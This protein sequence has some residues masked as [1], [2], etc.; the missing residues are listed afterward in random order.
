MVRMGRFRGLGLLVLL[1]SAGLAQGEWGEQ[2]LELEPGWNAVFLE[3]QPLEN[4]CAEVFAGLPVES[5]WYWNKRFEPVQFVEDPGNLNPRQPDWLAWFPP[6]HPNAFLTDLFAVMAGDCYLVQVGGGARQ[7]LLLEGRRE[8]RRHAWVPDSFNFVGFHVAPQSPPTF[9]SFFAGD[10]ALAG[11][12]IYRTGA[13]GKNRQV[14]KPE[15]ETLRRGEAYWVYCKGPSD[16]AGPLKVEFPL[17]EGLVYGELL[18][19]QSLKLTNDSDVARKVTVRLLPSDRPDKSGDSGLPA[20]GGGVALSYYSL[21][22]WA[23]LE[24]PLTFDMPPGRLQEI[25]LAVRRRDMSQSGDPGALYES[26]LE[27][28]DD[29]GMLYRIP[30]SSKGAVGY[31]GLWVGTVSLNA[32]SEA[33]NS[34]DPVT[35]K[36]VAQPFNF[37]IIVHVDGNGAARLLQHVSLM[38]VQAKYGPSPDDPAV[39]V[40][41]EPA[42]YVV[43][44]NDSLIPDYQGVSMRDGQMVGR[45]ISAPAFS[46]SSPALLAGQIND[47]L[48]G[49]LQVG[50]QDPLNPFVHKFHPDHNNLDERHEQQL[51]EG[52]ESYTFSRALT[53][54][55]AEQDPEALGLPEWGYEV[56]GGAYSE[57]LSGVHVRDIYMSGT[58]RLTRVLDVPVL[59]DGR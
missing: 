46:L 45:R 33:G 55:F 6:E 36:P 1:F 8:V 49:T 40:E 24:E 53:L 9:K 11:Q 19:E 14:L 57:K 35:T 21:I 26:V 10:K 56:I 7:T 16:Y 25:Q 5:V 13:D 59:N 22:S 34:F 23:K 44:S 50:Y 17:R 29:K 58:F 32:V 37:R 3:V 51:P 48:K 20:L 12:T 43:L 4:S 2:L 54:D 41:T 15:T 39:Q 31:G 18:R 42:R 27:V 52:M 47:E 38:Q 30:V 28:S